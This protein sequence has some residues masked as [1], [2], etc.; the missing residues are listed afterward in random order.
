[1]ASNEFGGEV[2]LVT[3]GGN[4]IGRFTCLKL[5]RDGAHV[6][7]TDVS[8]E[9]ARQT[10]SMM[11]CPEDHLALKMD[12][13][14]QS[15]VQGVIAASKDRFGKRPSLL[16]NSAGIG[17]LAPF[18][19][20]TEAC[21]DQYTSINLKGTILVTQTFIKA[22]LEGDDGPREGKGAVVN[23]AS[24]S[25]KTGLAGMTIYASTKAGVI[26]FSK[27]CAAE[28]ARKGIRVNCVLPALIDTPMATGIPE[29]L[30]RSYCEKNPLG[31]LGKP[32]EV[33]EVVVFLLSRRSSYMV[34]ACVEVSGGT[35]M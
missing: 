8:L 12:V 5:A 33:A 23:I 2:A 10:L 30:H 6:V 7:V 9:A 24:M 18:L 3:G 29:Q 27:S 11:P 14:L 26:A 31:R 22:L 17:L 35:D 19:D 16:V 34:G 25:G 21:I 1:M 20:A 28:M 4:G 13:T 32:E 15:D